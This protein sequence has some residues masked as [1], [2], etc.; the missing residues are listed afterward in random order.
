ML[1]KEQFKEK[2]NTVVCGDSYEVLKTLPDE[3]VNCVITSP[4]YYFLRS[5]LPAEHPDKEKEV[6]LEKSYQEYI[7]NLVRVFDEV[8]RVLK[9]D[10][11]CFVNL[12]DSYNGNK[13]G[14]T[15]LKWKAT[16]TENF[17]KKKQNMQAKSL[18]MIPE[19]FAIEMISHGWIL[20]NKII[21]VKKN[22]MPESVKDRWKKA[23]EYIFFFTK[24]KHYYFDLDA[25]RTPHKDVSI[26]RAKYEQGRNA[27]GMNPS[28][29]GEKYNRDKENRDGTEKH[30]SMPT[31]QLELNPKGAVPP[32]FLEV[33]TNCRDKDSIQ[34]HYA[35]YPKDLIYPLMK[36]GSKK[37]DIILDPFCGSGTTGVV[38][39]QL[40]RNWIMIDLS[41]E[42]CNIGK[43]RIKNQLE[44]ML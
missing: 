40:M 29:M 33:M 9:K 27:L 22:A 41:E 12:G 16:N 15:N 26:N 5:Y 39:K 37:G 14:N 35:T 6:G 11:C 10:G 44:P 3:S 17:K 30:Y 23:H 20:R 25:I 7:N 43:Q 21:W 8:K 28:S 13:I 2:I 24:N 38:A 18:M 42:Y 19:R 1:L 4:P 36:A 34:S 31:R 32:D